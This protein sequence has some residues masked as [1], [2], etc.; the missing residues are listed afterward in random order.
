MLEVAEELETEQIYQ[1]E[2]DEVDSPLD[3]LGRDHGLPSATTTSSQ[4]GRWRT[5]DSVL[6]R[7]HGVDVVLQ[8]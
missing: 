8:V 6:T 1:W 5:G 2:E 7:Q 4:L 3:M